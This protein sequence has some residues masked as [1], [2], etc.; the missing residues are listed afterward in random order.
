M[1]ELLKDYPAR[2]DLVV[3]SRAVRSETLRGA[4]AAEGEDH[5]RRGC[6]GQVH[7]AAQVLILDEDNME[8]R[9]QIEAAY[10]AVTVLETKQTALEGDKVGA[11]YAGDG[12]NR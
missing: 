8:A 3:W 6:V 12:R 10:Q 11:A 5:G 9:Q 7:P 4:G 1:D 2:R